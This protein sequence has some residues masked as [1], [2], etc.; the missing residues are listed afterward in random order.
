M[1]STTTTK[2]GRSVGPRFRMASVEDISPRV[3]PMEVEAQ[4][5]SS[6]DGDRLLAP[7]DAA[8][9][10]RGRTLN[11]RL[12][13]LALVVSGGLNL[14]L[15]VGGWREPAVVV[16]RGPSPSAS[17]PASL[18]DAV[19][20]R[21][22]AD[23]SQ[24]ACSQHGIQFDGDEGCVCFDCWTGRTCE[25]RLEGTACVVQADGGTPYVFEDYWVAHPSAE[26]KI[27]PSYHIG[28]EPAERTAAGHR[29][30]RRRAPATPRDRGP[31]A[32]T[33]DSDGPIPRLERAIRSLHALVGNAATEGRHLVLGIGSTELVN[34]AVYALALE[35]RP[36]SGGA[37]GLW[38]Q[39]PWYSGYKMPEFYRSSLFEWEED[40]STTVPTPTSARPIVE[41]VTS[42][43]NPDGH[44]R[45]PRL[46]GPHARTLL[47]HAYLWPHFTAIEG[48]VA[49]G[50]ETVAL[51]TLSKMTG[52]A[53]TRI[54]W[55]LTTSKPV[56]D[57]MRAFVHDTTLGIPRES[58]LRAIAALEH[59]VSTRGEIF[60]YARRLML[61]RWVRLEAIFAGSAHFRLDARDPPAARDNF[62]GEDDYAPSPAYAWLERIDGGDAYAALLAG[63]VV[64][65]RGTQFGVGDNFVRVEL[66]MR[67][68]SFDILAAKL[69][70]IARDGPP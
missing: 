52:H 40:V 8:A 43:N 54:G 51:F 29:A 16:A 56:A 2:R 15:I 65:R 69:G 50:N 39:T 60:A 7:S 19:C 58:Q 66:L 31:P 18:T 55:A 45:A 44:L 17:T 9:L 14:L 20:G 22:V 53:S 30:S 33:A 47:D 27:R 32:R 46:T 13:C 3:A 42:P 64:G 21:T 49:Y 28:C 61:G 26:I 24:L 59:V 37:A 11:V 70:P 36:T 57:K 63:G 23:T 41:L 6:A 48:P 67:E 1:Q 10:E 68:A 38:S 35:S 4:K 5:Q 25:T 12:L 34:A 62:F